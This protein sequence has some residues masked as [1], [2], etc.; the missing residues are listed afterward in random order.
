M[1]IIPLPYHLNKST[2]NELNNNILSSFMTTHQKLIKNEQNQLNLLRQS[3]KEHDFYY[4]KNDDHG[5]NNH[6]G[7]Y[8]YNDYVIS[9][10]T[11]TLQRHFTFIKSNE[12][13][14]KNEVGNNYKKNIMTTKLDFIT[15]SSL[16]LNDNT[17]DDEPK[18][19]ARKLPTN[20][21]SIQ[22]HEGMN[23]GTNLLR[24]CTLYSGISNHCENIELDVSWLFQYCQ[25]NHNDNGKIDS[26]RHYWWTPLL[27]EYGD[28][29]LDSF[30]LRPDSRFFWN[31]KCIQP[32]LK[33]LSQSKSVEASSSTVPYE[34]LLKC[35]KP[36]TSAFV[37]VQK[38]IELS[39]KSNNPNHST[40]IYYDQLL[41]SRRSKYRAGTRFTKRGADGNGDVANF[42]ETE[43]I[44]IVRNDVSDRSTSEIQEQHPFL[45]FY[46]HVQ[47]RGSIPL[48]WSSPSDIKT[49]RPKV[50]IGTDPIAQARALRSHL[51]EQLST[52]SF[53]STKENMLKLVFVNLIDKHSD[54]GRL[55]K[56]FGSILD[57]VLNVY[58]KE[59]D[60]FSS[61]KNIHSLSHDFVSYVWFDFHAQCKKGRWYKLRNLLDDIAPTLN[62]Q[63]FFCASLQQLPHGLDWTIDR[64]QDGV[65]RTNCMDCLGK[66]KFDSF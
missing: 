52:Y 49:Y 11:H 58:E 47:T 18:S 32:F 46:S 29:G 25:R 20:N 33:Q 56:M 14:K 39:S 5:K 42:A 64:M 34:L 36:V 27:R 48:R 65:V 50:L 44:C 6:V 19:I 30:N 35:T 22:R 13:M 54:Q 9:D 63:G 53:Q 61:Q 7:H 10:I 40:S 15:N 41:I 31:E 66:L 21:V 57:A 24:G 16:L 4:C 38:D 28:I 37:G 3:F 26:P 2:T 60:E 51:I 43:Q 55:G 59:N 23:M 1:E 8:D 17:D 12:R 62:S 45:E